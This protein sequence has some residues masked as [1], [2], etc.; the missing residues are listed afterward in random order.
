M[1][2]VRDFASPQAALD[3]V[4]GEGGA[5]Y[6][7]AGAYT[8]AAGLRPKSGTRLFGDGFASLICCADAGWLATAPNNFGLINLS[9]VNDVHLDGLR[10]RGTR[11]ATI[12][13]TPKLIYGQSASDIEVSGCHLEHSAFE[14]VWQGGDATLIRRW[15]IVNNAVTDVGLPAGSYVGLPAIQMNG[16][17][18]LIQGNVLANVGSGIGVSGRRTLVSG[19]RISG[20]SAVG[21]GTGDGGDSYGVSVVG[22][23]IELASAEGA[24]RKAISLNGGSGLDG[25]LHVEGNQIRIVGEAAHWSQRAIQM[26]STQN[27]RIVNNTIEIVGR[28]TG[29]EIYGSASGV[30]AFVD[31]NVMRIIAE[32]SACYAFSGIPNGA[33]KSL[34]V[35]SSN[36]R[37]MG[38]TGTL[39]TYAYDY[40]YNGGGTL[41]AKLINDWQERGNVRCGMQNWDHGEKDGQILNLAA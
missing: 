21:I 16:E 7:P 15:R 11:V 38:S 17:D 24:V 12:Q 10:L 23:S 39:G 13:Y 8:L 33:G 3:A 36:N 26:A 6:M 1:L 9:G 40:N 27:A 28:G 37:V 34:T 14:G 35:V 32:V 5:V 20:I 18:A 19:N 25:M 4:T 41:N 22:N 2:D 29:I 31:S 30:S